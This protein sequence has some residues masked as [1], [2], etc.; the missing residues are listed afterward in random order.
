MPDAE[1]DQGHRNESTVLAENVHEDL[2]HRLLVWRADGSVEVLNA[3]EQAYN[4]EEAKESRNDD[5]GENA[6]RRGVGGA[7]SFFR[8]M[9]RSIKTYIR[10]KICST[11]RTGLK[12][13]P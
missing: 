8:K 3:K 4:V 1:H 7:M 5:T 10:Q 6:D 12:T 13:Y 2:K 9:S 11:K